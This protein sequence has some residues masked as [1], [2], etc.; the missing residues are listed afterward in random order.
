LIRKLIPLLVLLP[1]L[2]ITSCQ[3]EEKDDCEAIS[4]KCYQGWPRKCN[5]FKKQCSGVKVKYTAQ[6]CQKAFNDLLL[7]REFTQI[8]NVYGERIEGCFSKG[9]ISKYKK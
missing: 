8:Q 3:S 7:G 4:M 6:L 9:E 5:D 2:S 1:L